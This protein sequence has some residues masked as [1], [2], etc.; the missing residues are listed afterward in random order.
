MTG[1]WYVRGLL[2]AQWAWPGGRQEQLAEAREAATHLDAIAAIRGRWSRAEVR[3]VAVLAAIAAAQEERDELA[4]LLAHAMRL[5]TQ[6]RAAGVPD[7]VIRP[8][9][10]LAGHLWLQV[11]RYTD[12]L[13]AY[14]ASTARHPERTGAWLGRAR[15]ARESGA[16][17]EAR[18]AAR[19]VLDAWTGA[20]ALAAVREELRT[21][22]DLPQARSGPTGAR[23]R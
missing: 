23:Q 14:R 6:V 7:D 16:I 18:E 21:L 10:E 3:R 5:E 13:D 8:I 11:H 17:E 20:P 2:S 1:Y 4:L 19:H 12:A 22:L 9:E 15:A